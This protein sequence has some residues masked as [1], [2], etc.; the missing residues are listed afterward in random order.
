MTR[1]LQLFLWLCLTQY[2]FSQEVDNVVIGHT[3]TIQSEILQEERAY[4]VSL[5][6]S[7]EGD[8]FYIDKKYPILI[9]L[10]GD[11]LFPLASTMIQSMSSGGT[12]QI[13]EMI[14]VGITNVNRNRDFLPNFWAADTVQTANFSDGADHFLHFIEK[15]LIPVIQEKYRTIDTKI[16]AGHS[17]GGLFTINALLKK[18]DFDAYLAIDPSLW[19]QE[20]GIIRQFQKLNQKKSLK[21]QLYVSQSNNPF[22]PGITG[23]RLGRA[24]QSFKTA[25]TNTKTEKLRKQFDFFEKD[26]HYSVPLISLYKGL[27]F[28][29]EGYKFP[30]H[31]IQETAIIDLKIHY[32]KIANRFGGDLLPPGKLLNQ[33]GQFLLNSENEIDKAIELFVFN[34]ANYQNT[35]IP[36]NSLGNAYEQTGAIVL[37]IENYQKSLAINPDN[38]RI[39]IR[40]ERLRRSIKK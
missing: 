12:E 5:P 21:G 31:K 24:V 17:F 33:V 25:I 16:L 1:Y 29:F 36:F 30:L 28:V 40:L 15:E 18:A 23:N 27:Q 26:D 35:A 14:V 9:I 13:P 19:W 4:M 20:E 11:R 32:Q 6:A 7:Y 37:A 34:G 22:N 38:E 39:S 8:H 2:G 10:D 3:F